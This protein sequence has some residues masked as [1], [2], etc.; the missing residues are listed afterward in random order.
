MPESAFVRNP[1]A[2]SAGRLLRDEAAPPVKQNVQCA[3]PMADEA[4]ALDSG[5]LA[6]HKAADDL[7]A[8]STVERFSL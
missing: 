4:I 2:P 5:H 6:L 8:D 7:L 1:A 3:P